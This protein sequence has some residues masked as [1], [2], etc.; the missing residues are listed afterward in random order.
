MSTLRIL[1]IILFN[2]AFTGLMGF[3]TL[4]SFASMNSRFA[5]MVFAVL[6][7]YLVVLKTPGINGPARSLYY[8]AGL[9]FYLVFAL[10]TVGWRTCL[11][12]GLLPFLLLTLFCLRFGHRLFF[13]EQN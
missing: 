8:G 5:A 11:H 7:P 1:G 2:V 4:D 6:I 9:A 12:T 3:L 13:W 10:I